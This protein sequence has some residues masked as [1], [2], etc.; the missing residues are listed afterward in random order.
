MRTISRSILASVVAFA[1]SPTPAPNVIGIELPTPDVAASVRFYRDALAWTVERSAEPEDAVLRHGDARLLLR[2]AEYRRPSDGTRFSLNVEVADLARAVADVRAAGGRIDDAEPKPFALGR[3]VPAFDPAGHEVHLLTL[4]SRPLSPGDAPRPFNVGIA[5]RDLAES[6]RFYAKLGFEV[7]SRDFLPQ[8]LPFRRHGAWPVVLHVRDSAAAEPSTAASAR[9]ALLLS[10]NALPLA[11]PRPRATP[12]G[13]AQVVRDPSGFGVAFV[14][15]GPAREWFERLLA[16]EG[17][18]TAKSTQGWSTTYRLERIARDSALQEF[19]SAPDADAPNRMLTVVTMDNDRLL[20]THYCHAGN[21]PR[22]V[23]DVANATDREITFRFLDGGNLASR[24][25]GHM[26]EMK[27]VLDDAARFR[28][29]W[30]W[31]QDGRQR[32]M[33]EIAYERIRAT[34]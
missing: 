22:L 29:T 33:E 15:R 6:E 14:E 26:D 12:L 27:L 20:L 25:V 28:C 30:Q 23:A 21:Q 19:E 17:E 5:C 34:R 3:M 11:E 24:D 9:P 1:P 7:F 13:R 31:Y 8:S 18:W 10:V 4:D 32:P 2:R 16:L